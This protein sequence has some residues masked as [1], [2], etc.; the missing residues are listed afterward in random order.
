LLDIFDFHTFEKLSLKKETN[1]YP[2]GQQAFIELL[3]AETEDIAVNRCWQSWDL[4]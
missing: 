2:F 3:V 4:H 1:K